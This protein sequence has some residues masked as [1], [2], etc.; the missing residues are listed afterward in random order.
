M[1]RRIKRSAR[2]ILSFKHWKMYGI[3]WLGAIIVGLASTGFAIA[4]EYADHWFKV[5]LNFSPYIPFVV[6]PLGLMLISW[7]TRSYFKGSEGSGIPQAIIASRS[8][9]PEKL[10]DSLLSIRVAIG[11]VILTF[12]GLLAGASIGREGPTIH[13]GA[14]IMYSIAKI[15]HFPPRHLFK[16]LILAG[17]ASGVATA[18]NTPLAGIMF[19][20]EE[21]ARSFE[22]RTISIVVSAVIISGITAIAIAGNY[23]YFGTADISVSVQQ[24]L[25]LAP[26]AGIIGGLCG[27]L[28]AVFLLNSL[29]W[30]S[31]LYKRSPL[32]VA[33]LAGLTLAFLGLASGNLIFGTGYE[34]AK[35]IITQTGDIPA[36]YWLYKALATV[37]SY[38]SGIPG[39]IFAPSLATGAG[40]GAAIAPWFDSIP[41]QAIILCTMAAYFAAVVQ[42]PLTALIIIMEMTNQQDM[43]L[44]ILASTFI[45]SNISRVI[46][47]K[48]LYEA[49]AERFLNNLTNLQTT[50]KTR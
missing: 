23:D 7:L 25:I 1:K 49:M 41:T 46:C 38:L 11:K 31:P 37:T 50:K 21:M 34:E 14:A 17:G 29:A 35:S 26:V 32:L 36:S 16:A 3:F 24:T 39:G 42:T 47:K 15:S 4:A 18:F 30:I 5:M 40:L 33:G 27:A 9:T 44:P 10:R 12:L 22:K 20:V 43:L 6:T 28:F 19:A 13:I 45:G 8:S 48:P 2:K